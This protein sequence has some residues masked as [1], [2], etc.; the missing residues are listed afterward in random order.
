M[1]PDAFYMVWRNGGSCPTKRHETIESAREESRRLA[2]SNPCIEFF[3]M[4]AIEGVTYTENPFRIRNFRKQKEIE[5]ED[6]LS[7]NRYMGRV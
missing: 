6:V 7:H 2:E 5:I 4:R 3:V 1:V